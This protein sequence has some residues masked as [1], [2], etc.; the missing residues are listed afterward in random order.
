MLL[1]L[2]FTNRLEVNCTVWNYKSLFHN[3]KHIWIVLVEFWILY[4]CSHT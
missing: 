4:L 3:S 2:L 1:I